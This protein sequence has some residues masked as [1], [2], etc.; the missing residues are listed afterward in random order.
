VA[1]GSLILLGALPFA[2]DSGAPVI[3]VS[4][5]VTL[6]L[7]G[8][9]IAK[10]KLILGVTGMLFPPLAL[11]GAIRLAEPGS[12]WARRRYPPGSRKFEKAHARHE[13]H[14]R[15]YRRFQDRVA[16]APSMPER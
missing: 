2:T 10:G 8:L 11:I 9:A 1:V 3:V 4:V 13:R 5:L 6:A 15:R 16:G 14:A 12:P 7:S